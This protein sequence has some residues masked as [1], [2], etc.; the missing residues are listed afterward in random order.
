MLSAL[1]QI[2]DDFC[3]ALF[4]INCHRDIVNLQVEMLRQFQI[5]QVKNFSS[6]YPELLTL[7]KTALFS[8][9]FET[10]IVMMMMVVVVVIMIMMMVM[11]V[12]VMMMVMIII[13]MMMVIIIIMM[14]MVM[15]INGV[16]SVYSVLVAYVQISVQ[17]L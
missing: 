5:Q 8:P 1:R 3:P 11:M 7:V 9:D 16:V 4:R 15:M 6:H 12:M 14:M 13:M 17:K 10:M 2:T